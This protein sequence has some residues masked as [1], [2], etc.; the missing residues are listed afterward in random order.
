MHGS[1]ASN[2]YDSWR[3]QR[4]TGDYLYD[5]HDNYL[6]G[7]KI[8]ERDRD[9]SFMMMHEPYPAYPSYHS[10]NTQ[11]HYNASTNSN[12]NRRYYKDYD[13]NF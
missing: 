7:Y 11:Q 13:P 1:S 2:I 6:S 12:S 9:P 10:N 4:H 5:S 8:K 3:S